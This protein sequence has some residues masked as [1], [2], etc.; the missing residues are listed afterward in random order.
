MS[1]LPLL[2]RIPPDV[3]AVADYEPLARERLSP[4]A[5]AY[6]NGGAADEITLRENRTAFER[7][8]L[9]GRVL[10]D[11]SNG[12]TRVT[13][14][15]QTFPFPILLSAIAYQK[16]LH[17][18][19]ELA[20]VLGATAAKAGMV[21]STQAT[22]TL[23]EIARQAQTPLWFQLYVQPDRGFT[24]EL[25]QRAESA[26]YTALVVTVDTP[27]LGPRNRQQRAGFRLPPGIEPVNLR[28]LA[29]TG[30]RTFPGEADEALIFNSL[31]DASVTW[32]DI[33]WLLS[34]TRLPVILKGIMTP[35]DAGRAVET[36][37]AGIVV[38]NHGGRNLDTLP[39][40][41]EVL[42]AIAEQVAGRVSLILDGGIR[43]GTDILKALALGANAVLVGR[44]YAHGLSAAGAIGVA[45]V[46]NILRAELEAAMA[47]TGC[48]NLAQIDRSVI[49][50][51]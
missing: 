41:I 4:A 44:P 20:T 6:L 42:P 17:P 16:L 30:R 10:T 38:S 33:G 1:P 37:V 45:H 13:L 2:Q 14:F 15:G 48:A 23:E 22:V 50:R 7:L 49:W 24:R 25:V 39:A 21:V 3:V 19:G 12:N 36:G 51:P 29:P 18:D 43:R 40:T 5:W 28:G 27:I 46:V 35:S 9:N 8:R 32:K 47:L 26:G 11:L 34:L 31:L